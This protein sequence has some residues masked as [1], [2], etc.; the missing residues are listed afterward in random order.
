M[1]RFW[2]RIKFIFTFR[3]S[4]PFI[5]EFYLSKEVSSLKKI[6]TLALMGFYILLPMDFIPDY[7]IVIGITDDIAVVTFI[8]QLMV[9]MAP[10]HLAQKYN[11]YNNGK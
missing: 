2:A 10:P 6:I 4:F 9:K 11:L 1:L 5:K 3:K 7:L 8:L